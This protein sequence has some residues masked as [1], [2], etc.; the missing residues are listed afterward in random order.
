M[1]NRY[2]GGRLPGRSP[3]AADLLRAASPGMR[4]KSPGGRVA[5]GPRAIRC[6][7]GGWVMPW[8]LG[9]GGAQ[10]AGCEGSGRRHA[11]GTIRR[12]CGDPGGGYD[13]GGCREAC[14]AGHVAAHVP[15][16]AGARQAVA[17]RG[18]VHHLRRRD[19][20]GIELA[21][22]LGPVWC[23]EAQHHRGSNESVREATGDHGS[24]ASLAR[25]GWDA[26]KAMI[27]VPLGENERSVAASSGV[28]Q[29]ERQREPERCPQGLCLR[30]DLE[31]ERA[32]QP[33]ESATQDVDPIA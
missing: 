15:V 25:R 17:H 11:V 14:A 5:V 33:D 1:S 31:Q 19:Q 28:S 18:A 23:C 24:A 4:G 10:P 29:G 6:L 9:G 16:T 22:D 32:R 3:A 12:A 2:R 26:P 21:H 7:A 20:T 30:P 27:N 13:E 8:G